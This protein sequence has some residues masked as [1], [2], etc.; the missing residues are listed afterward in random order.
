M[1]STRCDSIHRSYKIKQ[2]AEQGVSHQPTRSFSISF[3]DLFNRAGG[4]TSTLAGRLKTMSAGRFPI[5]PLWTVRESASRVIR[6]G[7]FGFSRDS[8]I[9]RAARSGSSVI[10]IGQVKRP[11]RPCFSSLPI[12]GPSDSQELSDLIHREGQDKNQPTSRD[13]PTGHKLFNFISFSF[14]SRRWAHI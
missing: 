9:L 10:P 3:Q 4:R 5:R 7:E 11:R 12:L 1:D 8:R 14:Q 13:A 2:E 6:C